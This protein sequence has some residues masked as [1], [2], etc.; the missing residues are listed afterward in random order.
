[1]PKPSLQ[2]NSNGISPQAGEIR[3]FILF[4]RHLKL[5]VIVL[6]SH[7]QHHNDTIIKTDTG[8]LLYK[9]MYLSLYCKGSKRLFK[10]CVWEGVGDRTETAIFWP[11]SY[12]RQRCV[13]LVLL[14]LNRRPWGLLC[15]VMAF[16]TA[17]H[18]HLLWPPT[19]QGPKP[20][21]PG[22]AFPTTS[23]L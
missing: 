2:K 19:H 9:N 16:F 11:H 3:N 1:M 12:G 10:V 23:W 18:Q 6:Y 20:L 21:R 22:V 13:F 17:S 7:M 5:N 15:W 8:R 4:P 14:M